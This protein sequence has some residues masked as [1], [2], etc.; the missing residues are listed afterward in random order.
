MP[1]LTVDLTEAEFAELR[2][3]AAVCGVPISC[4]AHAMVLEGVDSRR[5]HRQES[6]PPDWWLSGDARGAN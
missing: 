4:L 3:V 5:Q 6:R 2:A 1:S